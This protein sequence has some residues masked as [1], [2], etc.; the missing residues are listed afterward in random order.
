MD[1]TRRFDAQRSSVGAVRQF[2]RGALSDFGT[3]AIEDAELLV[4]EV[5]AN[6][7]DH[8]RTEYDVHVVTEG[9]W[10]RIEVADGS[11]IIP[12]VQDLAHDAERGRGLRLIE[13]IATAWGVEE[14]ADGKAVWF[15]LGRKL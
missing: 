1:K 7:V 12:A 9:P 4:S 15:E 14:R 13:H 2:V 6:V 8:A 5:A 10:V 3:D 11:S